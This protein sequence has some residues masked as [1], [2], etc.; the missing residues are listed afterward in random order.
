LS[1]GRKLQGAPASKGNVCHAFQVGQTLHSLHRSEVV[2][3][4]EGD[5]LVETDPVAAIGGDYAAQGQHEEA[6]VRVESVPRG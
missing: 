6:A 1:A 4:L 2:S 3:G 5:R